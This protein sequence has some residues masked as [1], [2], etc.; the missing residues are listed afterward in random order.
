MTDSQYTNDWCDFLQSLSDLIDAI[1]CGTQ[2]LEVLQEK[3]RVGILGLQTL[4]ELIDK[5]SIK[6]LIDHLRL[7]YYDLQ[8]QFTNV[9]ERIAHVS[10]QPN[11]IK[12]SAAGRPKCEISEEILL[13]FRDLG[14]RWKD[15]S[16]MLLVSRWTISRRVKEFGIE[17]VTGYSNISDDE[18]DQIIRNFKQSHGITVGRSLV[19]GHLKSLGIRVQ[20]KRV[21]KSLVRVDPD[22]SKIRWAQ[23]IKRR[24]YSVPGPNSLWHIDG[25]HSL[26]HWGFVIHGSID[27]FS[28]HITYLK[29]STNNRKE[30]VLKLF[31]DAIH[32]FGIPSRVRSDKGGENVLVWELIEVLRG[33]DRGSFLA[34]S[35]VHNQRIE[36]LWRDVW[37]CVCCEF[38]YAFQAM[39]DQGM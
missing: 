2:D 1:N 16:A 39:E 20:H 10:V 9:P 11:K 13:H 6:D 5:Q 27:G 12:S 29:C 35:S 26:I 32:N 25:H 28:R 8:R 30:T 38:Y 23:L 37:N 19:L 33:L 4:D 3:V 15:I 36:R 17:G 22:N 14:F 21:I 24:K 7:Y 34:S 18:L 31:E